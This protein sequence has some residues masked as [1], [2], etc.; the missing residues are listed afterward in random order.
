MV[1]GPGN[2]S[3]PQVERNS[4]PS[5]VFQGR[6][7]SMPS[8]GG[9]ICD[10]HALEAQLAIYTG[11]A[12]ARHHPFCQPSHTAVLIDYANLIFLMDSYDT[13]E[14]DSIPEQHDQRPNSLVKEL[15]KIGNQV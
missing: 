4:R 5:F 6:I 15:N 3:R 1:F 7:I 11:V 10:Q 8:K 14:E 9:I 12:Y 13:V 2:P